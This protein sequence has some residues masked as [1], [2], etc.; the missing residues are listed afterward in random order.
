MP[1]VTM[2]EGRGTLPDTDDDGAMHECPNRDR[3]YRY[4]ATPTPHRQAYF[5]G[6]PLRVGQRPGEC[7]YFWRNS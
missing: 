1:D 2:C 6:M 5:V 7:D 3:C 4:T